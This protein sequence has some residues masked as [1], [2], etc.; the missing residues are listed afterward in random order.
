MKKYR[1][2]T[3]PKPTYRK[4]IC[5]DGMLEMDHKGIR[6]TKIDVFVTCDKRGKTISFGN[7]VEGVLMSVPMED[8]ADVLSEALSW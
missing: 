5:V 1:K 4:N 8:I 3:L 7:V 2:I 6:M